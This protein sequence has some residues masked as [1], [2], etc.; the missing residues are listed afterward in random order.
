MEAKQTPTTHLNRAQLFSNPT[1]QSTTIF[2][3]NPTGQENVT[4][5]NNFSIQPNRSRKN[6][7]DASQKRDVEMQ[8]WRS[9]KRD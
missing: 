4:K 7:V 5:H 9:W 3:S 1:Q 6:T 8:S 2:Q